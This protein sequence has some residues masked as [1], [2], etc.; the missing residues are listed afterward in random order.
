L[1]NFK[2]HFTSL[3]SDCRSTEIALKTH[4]KNVFNWPSAAASGSNSSQIEISFPRKMATTQQQ[5]TYFFFF[6]HWLRERNE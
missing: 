3:E 2:L 6:L 1:D 5:I 4:W